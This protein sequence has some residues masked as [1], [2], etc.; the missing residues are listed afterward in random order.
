MSIIGLIGM[1]G[2]SQERFNTLLGIAATLVALGIFIKSRAYLPRS[3]CGPQR[4]PRD[5]PLGPFVFIMIGG[6]SLWVLVPAIMLKLL[7]RGVRLEQIKSGPRE[8]VILGI[9]GQAI[10]FVFMLLGTFTRRQRG[11]ETLGLT[12][13]NFL[14]AGK[15]AVAGFV[16]ILPLVSY[17]ALL[18]D[19]WLKKHNIEHPMKHELLEI[20]DKTPTPLMRIL[21]AFGAIFVAPLFEEFL[22]RAHLQTLLSRVTR[23]PWIAVIITS[24]LFALV[25]H[26]SIWLPI[27]TLS[28]CLG[29]MY[30]RTANLWVNILMHAMFNGFSIAINLIAH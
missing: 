12:R 26:W 9:V 23:L 25:H 15:A 27:F 19:W 17:A 18:S 10:P 4:L 13:R 8:T 11:L 22:F 24:I 1:L 16:F 28:L 2:F 5:E 6:L 30:E 7:H 14:V 21:I 20:M 29:Y 3:I